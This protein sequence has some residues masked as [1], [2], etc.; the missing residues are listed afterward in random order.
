MKKEVIDI[1][2]YWQIAMLIHN[3]KKKNITRK[4]AEC[5]FHHYR[6]PKKLSKVIVDDFIE[7]ELLK[8]IDNENLLIC[9]KLDMT[10]EDYTKAYRRRKIL[11]NLFDY[12]LF[13]I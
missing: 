12:C 8:K 6:I 13:T 7:L 4:K 11:E 9:N 3:D 5:F 2:A 10:I 1:Y